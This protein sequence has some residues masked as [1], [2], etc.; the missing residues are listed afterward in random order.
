MENELPRVRPRSP[1]GYLG[2]AV[3][4]FLM[5]SVDI[6]PGVSGGTVAFIV[7][8]YHELIEALR[9]VLA[10]ETLRLALR[11]RLAELARL[12]SARFLAAL[13]AGIALGIFSLAHGLEWLLE[14]YPALLWAF[15]FG[16][17]AASALTIT[18]RVRR[19]SPVSLAGLAFAFVGVYLLVGLVPLHTP[20]APLF[21]FLS[22]ALAVCAMILPGI[23]GAF[24]LV[25]LGK[26]PAVLAAVTQRDLATLALVV[27][28]ALVGL[29]TFARLLGWLFRRHHDLTVAVLTGFMLGSLRKIW[30]WKSGPELAGDTLLPTNVLPEALTAEVGAA[31]ALALGGFAAVWIVSALAA[32]TTG[33]PGAPSA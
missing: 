3:R 5:G 18:R 9:A 4:G 10:P 33:S 15:F 2:L 25:L 11:L 6:I 20:D 12:P 19:W 16:L 7:G 24:V 23:S 26:Y 28:G 17:V 30:P 29:A 32:R 31:A 13:T 27:A 14:R 21:F 22:G 8:I 1:A